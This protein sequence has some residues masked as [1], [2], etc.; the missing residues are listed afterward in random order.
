MS[1]PAVDVKPVPREELVPQYIE[2]LKESELGFRRE[3]EVGEDVVGFGVMGRLE[4]SGCG[5]F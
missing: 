5:W 2:K 3:Y 4:G 1:Q